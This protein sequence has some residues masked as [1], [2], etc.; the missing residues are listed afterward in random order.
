MRFFSVHKEFKRRSEEI[1][2]FIEK[3]ENKITN[4]GFIPEETKSEAEYYLSKLADLYDDC[5]SA[6]LPQDSAA[7]AMQIIILDS[8]F[9]YDELINQN[10]VI[11]FIQKTQLDFVSANT[12]NK[13]IC[14]NQVLK[15]IHEKML[16]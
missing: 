2:Q 16:S 11:T 3:C 13:K 9:S 10:C 12:K 1:V 4:Y 6:S 7:V 8:I 15:E 14:Y 5:V